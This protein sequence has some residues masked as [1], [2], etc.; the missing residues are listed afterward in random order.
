MNEYKAAF[1]TGPQQI[2][3]GSLP[4]PELKP[5]EVLVRLER[6]NLCPTDLKKYYQ[7]DEKSAGLLQ[8]RG[9]V[10]LG[11]EAAGIVAV[12][13]KE[14][15][16]IKADIRVAIDPMLPCGT[17][18]YCRAGD[19]PMCMNLKGIG[20][21]AGSM[22]DSLQLLA[23]GVGGTFA[24]YI[25]VPSENIYPLPEGLSFE[26]GALMEP[27]ADVL[28]SL[29]AGTPQPGETAVVFGL[30][31]MG[32]MHVRV[33]RSW[34]IDR[35]IGIDPIAQRR[36]KAI[37]FGASHTINPIR[38]DPVAMLKEL[39]GGM[40][41][42]VIFISAG[43]NAQKLCAQ[44]ALQVIRKKGR[45][46]LYASALKP[47]EISIDINQIHYGMIRFTGTVGFYRRHAEQAL[48]L[49]AE[50]AVDVNQIRTPTL[51]L[52]RLSEAFT[53]SDRSEV[54]KVGIDIFHD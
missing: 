18:S 26:A 46:L 38:E 34:G 19:F 51:P 24:E 23:E 40:G 29:E 37:E 3:I 41:A 17:C 11:H 44:Q 52:D 4:L 25:K 50:G 48:K 43:G 20:V 13:G 30:G 21:S 32:L 16:E 12:V 39:T 10:V 9:G 14:V 49:L 15:S 8:I 35:I 22:A 42:E 33:M 31:A 53:I 2:S 7:L 47:A 6:A 27:L 1:L 28:H 45:I 36:Q 54:V 5:D